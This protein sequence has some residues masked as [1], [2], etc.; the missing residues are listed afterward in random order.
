MGNYFKEELIL[1]L[2]YNSL[3]SFTWRMP[4]VLLMRI[5]PKFDILVPRI[6]RE[7]LTICRCEKMRNKSE[8]KK[9][10]RKNDIGKKRKN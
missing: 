4:L 8:K 3:Q 2:K 5:G 7:I 1:G 6:R 10:R 9:R